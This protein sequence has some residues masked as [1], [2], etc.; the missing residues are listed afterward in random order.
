[1]AA[2]ALLAQALGRRGPEKSLPGNVDGK[3]NGAPITRD[4][5]M[6][7]KN[8]IAKARA[9]N[10]LPGAVIRLKHSRRS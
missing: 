9:T 1:M 2:L 4:G 3:M 6:V 8:A 7:A 5:A 10:G